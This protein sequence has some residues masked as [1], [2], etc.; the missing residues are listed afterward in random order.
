MAKL[1]REVI[2]NAPVEKVFQFVATPENF[3]EVWPSMVD[4]TD[5]EALPGGGHKFSWVYKMAG[6][7]LNGESETVE[8]EENRRMVSETKGGIQSRFVWNFSTE[9]DGTKLQVDIEYTVPV[10]VAGKLAEGVVAKMNE[11]EATTLVSNIK[12]RLEA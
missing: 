1:E 11:R 8:Y 2:I 7:K 3:P 6:V 4:V 12:D 9:G 5:V 10:P